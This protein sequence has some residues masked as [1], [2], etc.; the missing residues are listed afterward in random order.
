MD[1][2]LHKANNV[3]PRLHLAVQSLCVGKED[4]RRRLVDAG[5][6][7]LPLRV[8]DFPLQTQADIREIHKRLTRYSARH[9][10][11]GSL[12]ATAAKTKKAT[13]RKTAELIWD[14]LHKIQGIRGHEM[15]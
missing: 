3:F 4:V 7:L 10:W 13:G 5:I 15:W 8:E 9:K 1:S 12:E 14:L 2:D 6:T 11:E